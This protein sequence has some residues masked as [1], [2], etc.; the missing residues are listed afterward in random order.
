MINKAAQFVHFI[1][2]AYKADSSKL[3]KSSD[4]FS[5]LVDSSTDVSVVDEEIMYLRLLENG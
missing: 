3:V 2:E 1:A 4:L 5:L